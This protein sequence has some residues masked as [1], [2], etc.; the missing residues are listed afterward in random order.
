MPD[1]RKPEC[2]CIEGCDHLVATTAVINC[3][4]HGLPVT[5]QQ[6]I[7]RCT[8]TA[9]RAEQLRRGDVPEM[10]RGTQRAIEMAAALRKA[11]EA[12]EF[13]EP[14]DTTAI[15]IVPTHEGAQPEYHDWAIVITEGVEDNTLA[16]DFTHR[17]AVGVA[18]ALDAVLGYRVY[19]ENGDML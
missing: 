5:T 1:Q 13:R 10:S 2:S 9:E 12:L 19:D 14:D 15:N 8:Y 7:E 4:V 16:E 18:H 3:R 11:A 6:D 17:T